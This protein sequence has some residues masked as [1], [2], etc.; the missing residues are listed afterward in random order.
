M[1]GSIK[2][3]PEDDEAEDIKKIKRV[4]LSY[5]LPMAWTTDALSC[6]IKVR[7]LGFG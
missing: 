3:A 6:S 5:H 7:G 1:S 2:G 4:S